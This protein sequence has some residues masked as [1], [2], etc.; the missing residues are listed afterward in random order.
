[1]KINVWNK[2]FINSI[3]SQE[4]NDYAIA[5][6]GVMVKAKVALILSDVS[7]ASR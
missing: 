2:I 4:K 6:N 1:M 7:D 5:V 3:L